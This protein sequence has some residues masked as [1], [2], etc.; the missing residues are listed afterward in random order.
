MPRGAASFRTEEKSVAAAYRRFA[1]TEVHGRSPLYEKL[2]SGVA[3]DL[4]IIEF[5]LTLPQ[6]KRQPNLLI[7]A[8]RHLCGT[9]SGWAELRRNVISSAGALRELMLVRS[10]RPTSQAVAPFC[11]CCWRDCLS[12]WRCSRLA[13]RRGSVYCPTGTATITTGISCAQRRHGPSRRSSRM[14]P[15]GRYRCRRC[16]RRSPGGPVSTSTRSMSTTL[17]R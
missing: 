5:L 16:C 6:E 8:A 9:P 10:T 13:P 7:A 15:L 1:D 12:R 2:A 14:H 4:T 11:C 17:G 3:A